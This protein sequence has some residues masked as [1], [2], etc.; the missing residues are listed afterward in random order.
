MRI[1][2]TYEQFQYVL[3]KLFD[4]EMSLSVY[5]RVEKARKKETVN[6]QAIRVYLSELKKE[7][8]QTV[9]CGELPRLLIKRTTRQKTGKPEIE[10]VFLGSERERHVEDL[11]YYEKKPSDWTTYGEIVLTLEEAETVIKALRKMIGIKTLD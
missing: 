6:V 7:V 11:N 5:L 10:I 9:E 2:L 3:A 8:N 1:P 4:I